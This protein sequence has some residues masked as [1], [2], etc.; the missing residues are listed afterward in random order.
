MALYMPK[1]PISAIQYTGN[2]V[3]EC[4]KFADRDFI[5]RDEKPFVYTIEFNDYEKLNA[6]DFIV[7]DSYHTGY[8]IVPEKIFLAKY[9]K[10]GEES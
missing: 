5:V 4:Q 8:Y 1:R 7:Y 2:N 9:H 6:G 10:V 3:D